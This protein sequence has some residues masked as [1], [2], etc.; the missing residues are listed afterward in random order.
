MKTTWSGI[1]VLLLISV[2]TICHTAFPYFSFAVTEEEKDLI[3]RGRYDALIEQQRRN[4]V[5][6][7]EEVCCSSIF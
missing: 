4:D 5:A 7:E 6:I 1:R 2:V 3:S